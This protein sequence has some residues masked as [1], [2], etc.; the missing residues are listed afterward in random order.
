MFT[1]IKTIYMFRII[2]LLSN[3]ICIFSIY[4]NC[5]DLFYLHIFYFVSCMF[6]LYHVIKNINN[7]SPK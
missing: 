2:L 6:A 7:M 4:S 3:Q 1:N 5:L